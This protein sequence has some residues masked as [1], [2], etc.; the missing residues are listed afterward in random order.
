VHYA[1]VSALSHDGLVRAQN[2][3]SMVVGPWATCA[4][5]TQTPQTMYFPLSD[6]LLVAVADGLGG[7]PAGE[8]ASTLVV[9]E[10]ARSGTEMTD[11]EA[12]AAVLER[13]NE[14]VHAEGARDPGRTGMGTTVAGIVVHDGSVLVFNVGDSRVYA[15]DESGL[16]Q[17]TVDDN[18]PLRPGQT[19]SSVLTQT[20]GGHQ[21]HHAIEPHVSSGP[22]RQDARF[23]LCTDGLSD[24]VDAD[25]ITAVLRAHQGAKVTY[26]L[27]RAAIDAGGLDNITVVMVELAHRENTGP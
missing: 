18:P 15:L 23:L 16:S 7:H 5:V 8:T 6:P 11:T 1:A 20:L 22:W 25:S 17:L 24:L 3:D 14:T 21:S 12:V 10:L 9:Q 19:H 27:W 4:T 26:E 2:E 13:C